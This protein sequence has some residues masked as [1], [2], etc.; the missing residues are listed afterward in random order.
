VY[1]AFAGARRIAAGSAREVLPVLKRRF[2]EDRT[3]LVLVFEVESGRQVDFDLRGSLED[4]LRRE[5]A[6][7]RRAPGRPR[8]GVTS[9][10]VSLL[11]R[12]WE[13]LEQQPSGSSAALRRLVEQALKTQPGKERARRIRAAL[14]RFLTSMA[15][16]RPHFEEASRALFDGDTA[17]FEAL[18]ERWPRDV[19]EHAVQRAREAA[20]TELEPETAPGEELVAA[21]YRSVWSDGDYGAIE[22]LVAPR[23]TI[24]SDPGDPWEGRSLDLRGY[25][26]RVRYSR[27]AFP[28]LVF[29]IHERVAARDRVAVRWSAEGTHAGALRDLPATGRRVGFAGQTTYE[30]RDGKVAGHWQVVDRLGFVQQLRGAGAPGRTRA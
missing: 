19:R 25:E 27:T 8:L 26:E 10:E 1:V 28:D 5:A 2:D 9:R 11:P 17:R 16:D 22:R 13:W 30:L 20:R 21:L 14:S 4:V 24:H 12:H 7:D 29:T 3:E 23:Y 6:T 15:G 18:V